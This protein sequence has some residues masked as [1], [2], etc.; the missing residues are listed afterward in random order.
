M[1]GGAILGGEFISPPIGQALAFHALQND[2]GAFAVAHSAGVVA[3]VELAAVAAKVRFA[4]VV[5]GADHAA[6]EDRE[7]ILGGVAVLEAA[8]G[9]VFAGAV[10]DGAVSGELAAKAGVN[11]RFV[12]HEVRGAIDVRNDQAAN[13]LGGDVGDV[14][15]A[16]V[17]FTL[18]QREDGLLGL[19]SAGGAVLLLTTDKGFI[20]FDDLVTA[21]ERGVAKGAVHRLTDAVAKEPSRLV[22]NAEH[23]LHLLRAHALL[24]SG[25]EVRR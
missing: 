23:T 2:A 7:E 4:H 25:H 16:N 19:H 14:E 5:I 6:L 21:A 22:G 9:D 1:I 24:G 10:I 13:V 17:A 3:K 18:D 11:G 8:S 15:T 12:G 20:G